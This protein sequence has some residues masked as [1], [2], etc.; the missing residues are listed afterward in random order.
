MF[1]IWGNS[2]PKPVPTTGTVRSKY[3]R[4]EPEEQHTYKEN[5]KTVVL[6]FL[7]WV[8]YEI[9]VRL[10]QEDFELRTINVPKEE[11]DRVNVGDVVK[12]YDRSRDMV[13]RGRPG[14]QYI[15]ADPE[16]PAK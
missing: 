1:M 2:P 3:V 6:K 9:T 13:N 4:R 16:P 11:F 5:G 8:N 12:L 15:E 10:D 14:F 7:P